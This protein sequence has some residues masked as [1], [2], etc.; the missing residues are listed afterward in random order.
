[1]DPLWAV[2]YLEKEKEEKQA[3]ERF[4]VLTAKR[5][6]ELAMLLVQQKIFSLY[7]EKMKLAETQAC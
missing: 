7:I 3:L 5:A 6:T 4:D 1:M 2:S